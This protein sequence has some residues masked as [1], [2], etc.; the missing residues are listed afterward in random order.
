MEFQVK[1]D[2]QATKDLEKLPKSYQ[3]KILR[4]L[5]SLAKNAYIGK[6][7]A[8]KLKDAYSYRVG[9]YRII[10]KVYKNYLLVIIIR[11]GHRQRIYK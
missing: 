10:Y 6:K 4:I 9:T 5:L 7:L 3:E 8:G 1:I 2:R 11:I